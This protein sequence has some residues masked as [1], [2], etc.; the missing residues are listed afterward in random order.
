MSLIESEK[1]VE[2]LLG[3]TCVWRSIQEDLE[4]SDYQY[5]YIKVMNHLFSGCNAYS[6]D[7]RYFLHFDS[8][9]LSD[10]LH[11]N[12]IEHIQQIINSLQKDYLYPHSIDLLYLNH[13]SSDV[14]Y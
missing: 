14:I 8:L 2:K 6:K 12:K 3:E 7:N 5:L 1:L 11:Q 10:Q 4:L 9:S 13:F